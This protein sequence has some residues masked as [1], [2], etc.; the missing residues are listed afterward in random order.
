MRLIGQGYQGEDH[1]GL[2]DVTVPSMKHAYHAKELPDEE[3]A[4]GNTRFQRW[5]IGKR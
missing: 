2:K 5:H 4:K 3:F 1:Y